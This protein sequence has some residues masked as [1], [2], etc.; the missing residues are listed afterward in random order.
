MQRFHSYNK[1]RKLF[2]L[3]ATI[4]TKAKYNQRHYKDDLYYLKTLKANISKVHA[5]NISV[6]EFAVKPFF[7]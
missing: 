4:I 2:C 5:L 6:S 1:T 7:V 3:S